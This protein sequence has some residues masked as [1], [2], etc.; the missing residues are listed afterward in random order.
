MPS[1]H[2][3]EVPARQLPQAP[4]PPELLPDPAGLHT[5]VTPLQVTDDAVDEHVPVDPVHEM[6]TPLY[7]AAVQGLVDVQVLLWQAGA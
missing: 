2:L 5:V 1:P 4:P 6:A 7:P 3:Q